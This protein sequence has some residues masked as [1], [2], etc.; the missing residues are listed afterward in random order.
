MAKRRHLKLVENKD[1]LRS[2]VVAFRAIPAEQAELKELQDMIKERAEFAL[3]LAEI[4]DPGK[5]ILTAPQNLGFET[6]SIFHHPSN[7]NPYLRIAKNLT[8][9]G[10]RQVF[11]LLRKS[12]TRSIP[13]N[14]AHLCGEEVA[15][16][17]NIE[18]PWSITITGAIKPVGTIYHFQAPSLDEVIQITRKGLNIL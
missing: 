10:E 7:G 18:L 4:Y 8:G 5:F 6:S 3:Q 16:Q 11:D 15:S 14:V 2:N 1:K 9:L 17:K 13:E 12:L